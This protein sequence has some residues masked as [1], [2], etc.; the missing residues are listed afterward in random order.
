MYELYDYVEMVKYTV[1][2]MNVFENLHVY[3]M[4]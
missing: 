3:Q 4:F 2:N 1:R